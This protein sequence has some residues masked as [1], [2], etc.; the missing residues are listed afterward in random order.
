MLAHP[1]ISTWQLVL[2]FLGGHSTSG[3]ASVTNGMVIDLRKMRN[4]IV[5]PSDMTLTCDGGC[6]WKDVDYAAAEHSLA[7]VGGTVNQ[8][9]IGGLTLGGGFGWLSGQHGLAVDRLVGA[10]VVLASGCIVTCSA[11]SEPDLFWALRGAG[12]AFGVVTKFVFRAV[13]QPEPVY[14]G[15]VFFPPAPAA[16]THLVNFANGVAAASDGRSGMM[17]G[18][19]TPPHAPGK[20]AVF[21]VCFF[22]GPA[23]EGE[24]LFAPLAAT[25]PVPPVS[26]TLAP[27]PYP[28]MNEVLAGAARDG[29]RRTS[30][31]AVFQLPLPPAKFQAVLDAYE[32]F[33]A[34]FPEAG[35]SGVCL[36]EFYCSRAI[37]ATGLR[38]TAF[39]SRGRHMNAMIIPRW[40]SEAVDDEARRFARGAL[41]VLKDTITEKGEGAGEYVNYDGE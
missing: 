22:N 28:A 39:S 21:G 36:F 18:F 20:R 38:D 34:R 4:V 37:C 5:S 25:A 35:E 6:L 23:A 17:V 27:M 26:N 33:V 11:T 14:G 19:T 16:V 9:G 24:A 41:D 15:T 10:E 31:G 40:K 29:G 13:A 12:H 1:S 2:R 32:A 30:K 7:T 3:D 8:T